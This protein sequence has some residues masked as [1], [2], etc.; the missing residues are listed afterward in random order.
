MTWRIEFEQ[1]A[2]REFRKLDPTVRRRIRDYLHERVMAADVP[3][4]YGKALRGTLAGLWRYRVG[5]HRVVCEIRDGELLVL[6]VRVAHR[7][8]AYDC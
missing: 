1:A 8:A 6:V 7:R 3:R 5:D 4:Q 2:A